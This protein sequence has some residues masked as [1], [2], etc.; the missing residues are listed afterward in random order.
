MLDRYVVVITL[1]ILGAPVVAETTVIR[2]VTIIDIEGECLIPAQTVVMTDGVIS[3]VE[4]KAASADA[5]RTID[6]A[7]KFLMPSLWDMHAHYS[8][9]SETKTTMPLLL[10]HGVTGVRIMSSEF[11]EEEP[12][13]AWLED[14]H[15][16]RREVEDRTLVAPRIVAIATPALN[17]RHTDVPDELAFFKTT[18]E[19]EARQSVR[20]AA[21]QGCDLIKIYD[22]IPRAPL[23]ALLDEA[24]KVGLHAGGHKPRAVGAVEASNAGMRTFEHAR[25]LVYESWP[26]A[27]D[28]RKQAPRAPSFRQQRKMIAQHDRETAKEIIRTFVRNGTWMCPT[29]VTRM[30]DA[31]A[32]DARF[33]N[34][35][36][37]QY[38]S[39]EDRA[40]WNRDA[41]QYVDKRRGSTRRRDAYMAIFELGLE[42]T[43]LADS[44]GVGILLGTDIGDSY[45]FPGSSTHQ[46]LELLVKAGLSPVRA[47]RTGTLNPALYLGLE[48]DYGTVQAG[49]KADLLLLSKNPLEDIAH[50]R[51]I[52]TLFFNGKDYDARALESMKA[53]VIELVEAL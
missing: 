17:G 10:A 11:V 15:R 48:E 32:G 21:E 40:R 29:H 31:Y 44:M 18:T 25:V 8:L 50:T 45:V 43:G 46:E 9:K 36:R 35:P 6:G 52:H 34:D 2:D 24:N 27:A 49:K 3:S 12:G 39:D 26:G 30:M 5:D 23:L 19:D 16:W 20:Y 51:A 41:N 37:L 47:L 42:L 4:S 7:G 14:Y 53:K 22:N 38:I 28:L 13:D 33:R 1:L